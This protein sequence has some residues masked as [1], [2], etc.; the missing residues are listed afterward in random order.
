MQR[1][2]VGERSHGRRQR[3][4]RRREEPGVPV[5]RATVVRGGAVDVLRLA[6][7]GERGGGG[8][9]G[10]QRGEVQHSARGGELG[11]LLVDR[12]HPDVGSSG[13]R[14]IPLDQHP[15][16]R[17]GRHRGR[18]DAHAAV[19]RGRDRAGHGTR[20]EAGE[21]AHAEEPD[22]PRP[23]RRPQR[24]PSRH[25]LEEE[26][27]G[28]EAAP[29]RRTRT[30]G[31][32]GAHEHQRRAGD[33]GQ[34]LA[35]PREPRARPAPPAPARG[36]RSPGTPARRRSATPSPCRA[37]SPR[38]RGADRCCR[39]QRS[40]PG[41]RRASGGSRAA[42]RAPGGRAPP[43][44]ACTALPPPWPRAP[45]TSRADRAHAI[46]PRA[47]SGRRRTRTRRGRTTPTPAT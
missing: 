22:H 15:D 18:D 37:A 35:T 47:R 25:V 19:R 31:E 17:D 1:I 4:P 36:A 21:Q 45:T 2:G 26:P 6:E 34:S 28:R 32:R 16:H 39:S 40:V 29:A 10:L 33:R 5:R 14:C 43:S 11:E 46:A 8:A 44:P 9:A 13:P 12:R 30:D 38:A 20:T 41:G 3:D 42:R 7:A 23:S 27:V 24:L